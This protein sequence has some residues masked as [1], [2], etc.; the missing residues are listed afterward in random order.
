MGCI[1]NKNSLF[2]A[3]GCSS[4][5]LLTRLLLTPG[6][7]YA[8]VAHGTVPQPGQPGLRGRV[9]LFPSRLKAASKS[10]FPFSAQPPWP[11][12][13]SGRKVGTKIGRGGRNLGPALPL[14]NPILWMGWEW[15][16]P[17]CPPLEDASLP[18]TGCLLPWAGG[19]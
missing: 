9:K 3:M 11:L 2:R 15:A 19:V 10:G 7:A 14:D 4:A 16:H 17:S 8:G 5:L 12:D 1:S 13:V 6:S 18:V